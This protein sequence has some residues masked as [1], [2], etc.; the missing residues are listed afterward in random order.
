MPNVVLLTMDLDIYTKCRESCGNEAIK[1]GLSE[2]E[3]AAIRI[4][5]PAKHGA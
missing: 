2:C 4:G 3:V 1:N 5:E